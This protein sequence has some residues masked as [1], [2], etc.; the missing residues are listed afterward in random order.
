LGNGDGSNL[1]D[2]ALKGSDDDNEI[3][4]KNITKG[5]STNNDFRFV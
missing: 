2:R 5:I 1:F 4:N 3:S